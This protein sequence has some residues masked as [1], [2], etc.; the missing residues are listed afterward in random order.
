VTNH[1][2]KPTLLKTQEQNNKL[3]TATTKKIIRAES[4]ETYTKVS[5]DGSE[6]FRYKRT[7]NR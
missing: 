7:Q 3:I 2:F 6:Q 5:V 1:I 4:A